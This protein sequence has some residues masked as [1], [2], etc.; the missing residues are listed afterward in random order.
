MEVRRVKVWYPFHL[1]SYWI[2][3]SSPIIWHSYH[4]DEN[5]FPHFYTKNRSNYCMYIV[6]CPHL[7]TLLYT[8]LCSQTHFKNKVIFFAE[9]SFNCDLKLKLDLTPTTDN[10]P[11]THLIFLLSVLILPAL[12]LSFL[13]PDPTPESFHE[14]YNVWN[15]LIPPINAFLSNRLFILGTISYIQVP[16][17]GWS[18]VNSD[19]TVLDD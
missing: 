6:L 18:F 5:T 3:C 19:C 13:E 2:F 16:Y 8:M 17:C 12:I 4:I 15:L 7:S 14:I 9:A 10:R 11:C 1:Y